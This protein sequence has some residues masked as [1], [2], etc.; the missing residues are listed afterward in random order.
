MKTFKLLTII[1]LIFAFSYS[2]AQE[3]DGITITKQIKT[4]SVKNQQNTG[5]CWSFATTS[6]IETEI[7]RT[8]N[9]EL[10]LSEM[11]FVYFAY[12]NKADKYFKYHGN[13]NFGQGG[14]AHDVMK[15]VAQ[16]GFVLEENYKGLNYGTDYHNHTELSSIL[17]NFMKA[18]VKSKKPTIAWKKA[19]KNI[20]NAYLGELPAKVNYKNNNYKPKEFPAKAFNFNPD[21]Y[22]EITSYNCYPEYKPVVLDV[23]DNWSHNLYYNLPLNELMQVMKNAIEN[24]YSVCWDGDVSEEEFS[25]RKGLAAFAEDMN[26]TKKERLET[27]NNY[28]TTD[29]HLM[30]LTGLAKDDNGQVFYQTKNSWSDKS[31]KFGGYLYMS[32]DFVRLKTVA[33][34]VHKNAIPEAIKKKLNIE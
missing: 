1:A 22:I 4:T 7:L 18:L 11:Y 24:G 15:V 10:D 9:A 16:H 28:T 8:K 33:V 27:F 17:E 29:D 25:H 3:K 31:N 14:Q 5:T 23:P 34:M 26:I 32:E 12:L 2:F 6:F 13:N 19:Y 20:L 30:H 21:D